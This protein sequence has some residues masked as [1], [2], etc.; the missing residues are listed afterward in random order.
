MI[1]QKNSL[2]KQIKTGLGGNQ[3]IQNGA[4]FINEVH[5]KN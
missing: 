3:S 4:F 2:G 1:K 5:M